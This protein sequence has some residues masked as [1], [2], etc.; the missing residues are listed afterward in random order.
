[1][2]V[3]QL[4][5]FRPKVEISPDDMLAINERFQ[6]EVAP[7]LPGL[8]RREA[9]VTEDGDWLL[10]LRYSDMDSAAGANA[11]DTSEISAQLISMIDMSTM[12]VSFHPIVSQ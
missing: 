1:M 10:V 11:K 6:R 4:V 3:I 2:A 9:T 8:E 7:T 12:S 5:R